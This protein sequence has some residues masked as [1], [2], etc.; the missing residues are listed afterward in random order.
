[1]TSIYKKFIGYVLVFAVALATGFSIG[2]IYLNQNLAPAGSTG[3]YADFAPTENELQ[4]LYQQSLNGEV[5]D[6]NGMQL[7][8]IA[9]Y[10][11]S[12]VDK[13]KCV[14][15]GEV[16]STGQIVNMKSVKYKDTNSIAYYKMSPSKSVLGIKTP[17]ICAKFDY[18]T[19]TQNTKITYGSFVTSGP[20]SKDLAA[21][22]N[23]S[24]ESWTKDQ[25]VSKFKGTTD[26]TL[27][28]YIISSK[29]CLDDNVSQVSNNGD[30]TYSFT[31]TLSGHEVLRDAALCYT[32]E[33]IFTCGYESPSLQWDKVEIKVVVDSNF[34]FKTIDYY[35]SYT[36]YS[37]SIPVLKKAGVVDDFSSVYYYSEDAVLDSEVIK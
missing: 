19:K 36:L 4:T 14:T 11:L 24:G 27:V 37:S 5:E 2:K 22:F 3:S 18:N 31:I 26:Q 12:V 7:F 10:K 1:M 16:N 33:I 15:L 13:F 20:E 8:Q 35:E 17:E 30:G 28:P 21:T 23:G 6:F 34:M 29:T 25:Y 9:Q 32:E